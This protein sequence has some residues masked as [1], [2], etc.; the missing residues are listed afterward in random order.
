MFHY[1]QF[2]LRG[3]KECAVEDREF[4]IDLTGHCPAPPAANCSGVV[5]E[6]ERTFRWC[7]VAALLVGFALGCFV[8]RCYGGDGVGSKEATSPFGRRRGGGMLVQVAGR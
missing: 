6:L 1:A 5:L 7:F 4:K 8:G 2:V 3:E